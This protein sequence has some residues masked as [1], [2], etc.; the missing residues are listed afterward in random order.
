MLKLALSTGGMNTYQ[1][2]YTCG[3][4]SSLFEAQEGFKQLGKSFALLSQK[5]ES[6]HAV[7]DKSHLLP[8]QA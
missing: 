1:C 5:V 4:Q 2:L 7:Q 8:D 3:L 6:A